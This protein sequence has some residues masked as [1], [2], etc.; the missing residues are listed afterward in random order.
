MRAK[1]NYDLLQLGFVREGK[2]PNESDSEE[3]TNDGYEPPVC[4]V[5]LA[6]QGAHEHAARHEQALRERLARL[7]ALRKTT[8][9][10]NR[11]PF[12]QILVE[13]AE[14]MFSSP[15]RSP[16]L[17][18]AGAGRSSSTAPSCGDVPPVSNNGNSKTISPVK[19]GHRLVNRDDLEEEE[20]LELSQQERQQPPALHS[21]ATTTSN[22]TSNTK[23]SCA[24]TAPAAASSSSSSF[25]L[26]TSS[27]GSSDS[28]FQIK[29]SPKYLAGALRDYQVDGV[30]WLLNNHYHFRNAILADE[31]GLGKTLVS[32]STLATLK[33]T[34]H[35]PGPHLI[36]CP[37]SVLG[38]WF[39]E[40]RKWYPALSCFRFHAS[41][42]F[43]KILL[44]ANLK[45]PLK[46]DIV[47]TT[48]EMV[49][50]ELAAFRK[51]KWN[52]LIVDE[53][54]KLKNSEGQIHQ[55]L[56]SLTAYHRLLVTGT[57]LQN[58]LT[59]LWA[60]LNFLNPELF[61]KADSFKDW[62]DSREGR[63]D[64]HVINNLHQILQPIMLRR[65]KSDVN[66]GIPP[67]REIYVSCPITRM[68][69]QWYL[70][71]LAR[72]REA[73]NKGANSGSGAKA[74]TLSNIVMQLR[75]AIMHPYLFPEADETRGYSTNEKIVRDCGKMIVLD[76]LLQ[77]LFAD[78]Q[79]RHKCLVFS[80]MTSMLDIIE[81]YLIYRGY[82][83][84]R[85]DGSTSSFDRDMQMADF[86]NVNSDKFVFLL[87]TRAGG[88]GINLQA[89]NNVII[90]DSDWNP[91]MDLQAQD[92]AHRIG[93]KRE[94]RVFRLVTD[95]SIEQRI[96]ER[97]LA[98]LYLDAA[99]VQQGRIAAKLQSGAAGA[100]GDKV[101]RE[102]MLS[103]I[104]FGADEMF[105]SRNQD[106]DFTDADIDRLLATG[107]SKNSEVAEKLKRESQA[108]LASFKFGATQSSLYDFDGID[109]H[110]ARSSGLTSK[111]L[112]VT[113]DE[114]TPE[115]EL[116]EEFA[117][118]GEL[119]K[120]S[121]H[122]NL[123]EAL[124]TY[125]TLSNAVDAVAKSKRQCAYATQ[126]TIVSAEL[127]EECWDY[128]AEK[129]KKKGQ[130][131][132]GGGADD[133]DNFD[134]DAEAAMFAAFQEMSDENTEL[135]TKRKKAA[136]PKRPQ[137]HWCQL[138]NVKRLNE[139]WAMECE[140]AMKNVDK[141]I[142]VETAAVAAAEEKRNLQH[143]RQQN[144]DD[145]KDSAHDD[146]LPLD[147]DTIK[148]EAA[149]QAQLEALPRSV[150]DEKVRLMNEGNP[151][152]TYGDYIKFR[153]AII[154]GIHKEDF[155][156]ISNFLGGS[157]TP[158]Q[159]RR[160]SEGF[161]DY[162]SLYIPQFDQ[163]EAR[164]AKWAEKQKRVNSKAEACRW[165]LEQYQNPSE[166]LNFGGL[167]LAGGALGGWVD[168]HLFLLA[169]EQ[170]MKV[171]GIAAKIKAMPE[172]RFDAFL[173]TRD[174]QFFEKRLQQLVAHCYALYVNKDKVGGAVGDAVEGAEGG[175]G[176]V[177]GA[178]RRRRTRP[179]TNQD[180]EVSEQPPQPDGANDQDAAE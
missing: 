111:M 64:E 174:E 89:A 31:M 38:N 105:K 4:D 65:L 29:E 1:D 7:K 100:D 16:L 149:A 36:I 170:G 17:S 122:P 11:S 110:K 166:E 30:N 66:T 74:E 73:V 146:V 173:L 39:R 135:T 153:Q 13:S 162:G 71:V 85:I 25:S 26:A 6:A 145:G 132:G 128:G 79:G 61:D 137:I 34:F 109:Y 2:D 69:R 48:Y 51:V 125:K 62:F 123:K 50:Y 165:K 116:R 112:H 120:L 80:Q 175:S 52:Y 151:N 102:E 115:S 56:A 88:V 172:G 169:L 155:A 147:I 176:S 168:R 143:Q 142:E 156:A 131:G 98:K 70:R 167:K 78:V 15:L 81:D 177:S 114:A 97:S 126:K 144:N 76:K 72:D 43:R 12:D 136:L 108:S 46:Y 133:G 47:V 91:Q 42:A 104:R 44:N 148:A 113:L 119:V 3:T 82:K 41:S 59:E 96:Y 63:Q 67:K 23:A 171:D 161:W 138:Y 95:N 84:C 54:H 163:I 159:V 86:N 10:Q 152:W 117:A 14:W 124:V 53:A 127:A 77:K 179:A 103:A 18:G 160:Y 40:V 21:R 45:P 92:R 87:S 158:Q 164:Q 60:L 83:Y 121:V 140:I 33:Y 118:F 107:E 157:Q 58:D 101:T 141:L 94:V 178:R 139:I 24:A 5:A 154:E 37:K 93:Q 22:N 35:L 90:Y 28:L 49:H 57:P 8:L 19:R 75:K 180:V 106:D 55:A 20:R 9:H 130:G 32:L 99:V 68:Q 134:D 129:K 27:F 150:Q